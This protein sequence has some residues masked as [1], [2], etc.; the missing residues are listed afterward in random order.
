AALLRTALGIARPHAARV[1]HLGL[2]VEASERGIGAHPADERRE[3]VDPLLGRRPLPRVRAVVS[4]SVVA[5]V[6]VQRGEGLAV[7]R[8]VARADALD[9]L[10]LETVREGELG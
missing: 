1:P 5:R 2:D 6:S 4:A 9:L 10:E 7:E 8:K 3:A